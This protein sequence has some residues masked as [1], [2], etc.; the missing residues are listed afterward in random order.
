MVSVTVTRGRSPSY[1]GRRWVFSQFVAERLID[2]AHRIHR[3]ALIS[4]PCLLVSFS[5]PRT[6]PPHFGLREPL[7]SSLFHSSRK[8]HCHGCLYVIIESGDRC[9]G[10]GQADASRGGKGFERGASPP[11][12]RYSPAD[13]A[14]VWQAKSKMAS[15]VKVGNSASSNLPLPSRRFIRCYFWGQETLENRQSSRYACLAP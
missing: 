11:R 9:V 7:T 1:V 12:L 14:P 4:P 6:T 8:Q 10:G 15:Q 2:F 5:F 13:F 3:S